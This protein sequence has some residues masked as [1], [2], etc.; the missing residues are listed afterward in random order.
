M[1]RHSTH[2]RLRGAMRADRVRGAPGG[3][4]RLR[5]AT[6]SWEPPAR[7][8]IQAAIHTHPFNHTLNL[9]V[10]AT[11]DMAPL[12]AALE[13]AIRAGGP[14]PCLAH[15]PATLFLEP[16]FVA[17]YILTGSLY[18][19]SMTRLDSDD[20]L[21]IDGQGMLILSV[22]KDTYQQLG[23]AGR[24]CRFAHG[25]SGRLGDRRSGAVSRYMIQLPLADP[26]FV[27]GK[28]GYE[29]ARQC[30]A[31]W[32]E[33]RG[34]ASW[35]CL[36]VWTPPTPLNAAP[37][38]A[39]APITLPE[40]LVDPRHVRS[41]EPDA[42]VR[43][44]EDV[45]VPSACAPSDVGPCLEWA[46]LMA[47][48]SPRLRAFDRCEPHVCL[49]DPPPGSTPGACLHL[50]VVGLLPPALVARCLQLAW[51]WAETHR[52]VAALSVSGFTDTPIAWQSKYPG[53]GLPLGS[54]A[55]AGPA[56]DDGRTAATRARKVRRKGHI[57][58]GETEHG[59]LRTGE[60]GYTV[61]LF[62]ECRAP[63]EAQVHLLES[64]E[65]DTH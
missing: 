33:A 50:R 62:P 3:P 26:S 61:L 40:A 37:A 14:G 12:Q 30:L 59:L 28:R 1:A 27:P 53:H 44:H 15:V 51:D 47:L 19:L 18:A 48:P 8:Q 25:A 7:S 32:D 57:R 22:S 5:T 54:G 45:W 17:E 4:G 31:A 10:P 9:V 38:R 55:L 24:P 34:R 64:V 36:F 13:Q 11:A 35:P 6:F 39:W 60:N 2:K 21:C 58:A 16:S 20:T 63:G 43:M 52:S 46:G 65:L 41:V 29:R 23:L 49:Y 42:V 56:P